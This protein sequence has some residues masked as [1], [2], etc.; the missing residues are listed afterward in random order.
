MRTGYTVRC[1]QRGPMV[2]IR[3]IVV[4]EEACF[5][6]SVISNHCYPWVESYGHVPYA[7]SVLGASAQATERISLG[8]GEN[9][10]EHVVGQGWPSVN[11]PAFVDV[12]HEDDIAEMIVCG[13]DVDAIVEVAKTWKDAGFDELALVQAGENQ[14]GFCHFYQRELG[15]RLAQR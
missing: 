6:F 7:W 14:A 4:A 2:L 3:D 5:A 15:S 1:E 8:A 13:P 11:F 9:L 10:N 12:V